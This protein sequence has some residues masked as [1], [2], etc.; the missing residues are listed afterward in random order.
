MRP[1]KGG[2]HKEKGPERTFSTSNYQPGK[3]GKRGNRAVPFRE[4]KKKKADQTKCKAS[5][6]FRPEKK[7][8]GESRRMAN[9]QRRPRKGKKKPKKKESAIE[10]GKRPKI[11]PWR[12]VTGPRKK[13][14]KKEKERKGSLPIFPAARK[15]KH[16][17]KKKR[18]NRRQ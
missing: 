12:L 15:K 9:S 7:Q 14:K 11:L 5:N 1:R 8:E 13:K 17:K 2:K 6:K 18:G 10:R 3:K 16:K 4:K